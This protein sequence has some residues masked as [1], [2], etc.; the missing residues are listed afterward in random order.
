MIL[1]YEM[2]LAAVAAFYLLSGNGNCLLPLYLFAAFGKNQ[3]L[4]SAWNAF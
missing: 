4:C 3:T 1:P 2:C